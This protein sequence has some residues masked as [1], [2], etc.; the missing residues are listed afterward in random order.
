MPHSASPH[1]V[2][3]AAADDLP[4]NGGGAEAMRDADG[5]KDM[6]ALAKGGRT[7][8]LG[9][10]TRLAGNL[11]FFFI[12]GRLYGAAALGRYAYAVFIV[13]LAAQLCTL[14]QKRGIAQQLAEE[15]QHP[16]NIVADGLLL[17]LMLSAAAALFLW[18]V[19]APMFPSGN[20]TDLDRLLVL[21]IFPTAF[22]DITLAA[23]A[24]RYDI[25]TTVRAR[26]I[27]EPWSLSISAGL[28]YLAGTWSWFDILKD[29][30]LSMAYII[31]IFASAVAMIGPLI[32]SYGWPRQWR[33]HPLKLG[34]LALENTPLAVADAV[35]WGTRKLDIAILGIF[36][37]PTSVGVYYVAQQFASLPQKL[38]T[39]F[40]P[41]LGPAITRNLRENNYAGIARQVSQVGFWITAAQVGIALAL[42]IPGRG[43]LGLTGP[44]FVGGL[45]A[46]CFLLGAEV[47]AAPAVVSEA[48]LIYIAPMRNL[49]VSVA[50]IGLQAVLTITGMY[51]D[52][53]F[54]LDEMDQASSAAGALMVTLLIASIVKSRLLSRRL[55]M[56]ISTWR[57]PLAGAGLV[58]SL[59]GW[60]IVTWLPEAWQIGFGVPAILASYCAVIWHFGF[61]PDDRMLFRRQ[62]AAQEQ[63]G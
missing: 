38:K 16:A 42:G 29:S 36:A 39:S 12:S 10:L 4:L 13:Q 57:W 3:A 49:F 30:G 56:P 61:G 51:I 62:P 60:A 21:T 22:G 27:V 28:L 55:K 44:Q 19:P 35:E 8:F 63:T 15:K 41:L 46:L 23:L 25:A 33:P 53:A 5:Q 6:T 14:G 52:R 50:T 32:R 11:P 7:N 58:A 43:V 37:T 40:E 54:G 18:F 9:F 31:S 45:G 34:R 20:Y 17:S 59:L 26:S 24:Y 1:T 47:S 2:P 48:A